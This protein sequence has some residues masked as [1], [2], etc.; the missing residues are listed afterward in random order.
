VGELRLKSRPARFASVRP[1]LVS[2]KAHA[3]VNQP[4]GQ[5]QQAALGVDQRVDDFGSLP[6]TMEW[7]RRWSVQ[8]T[9]QTRLLSMAVRLNALASWLA[10]HTRSRRP[11]S[12]LCRRI[13]S[14]IIK[15]EPQSNTSKRFE[16][17]VH[18]A[19]LHHS[20]EGANF[21]GFVLSGAVGWSQFAV[22]TPRRLKS[23]R[24]SQSTSGE[25]AALGLHLVSRQLQ[26]SFPRWRSRWVTGSPNLNVGRVHALS[27][28]APHHVFRILLTA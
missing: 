14:R 11:A 6:S 5:H 12:T 21:F 4:F 20:F 15:E 22:S 9:R 23:A 18:K 3:L 27:W 17:A 1:S 16:A 19:A 2:W 8:M 25:G 7:S 26:A 24:C 13:R 28:R 10:R